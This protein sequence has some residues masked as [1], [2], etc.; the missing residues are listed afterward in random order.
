MRIYL[1]PA[2][3]KLRLD[4]IKGEVADPLFADLRQPPPVPW[5][6]RDETCSI[7]G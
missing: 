1:K 5:Q 4:E 2:L 6:E 7:R 3:G